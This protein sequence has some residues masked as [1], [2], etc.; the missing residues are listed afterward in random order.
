[1]QLRHFLNESAVKS[2]SLRLAPEGN[3][4]D[5]VLLGRDCM[6]MLW[7][8][9][10]SV[11]ELTHGRG[12]GHHLVPFSLIIIH[13]FLLSIHSSCFLLLFSYVCFV[14]IC[15][16]LWLLFLF[17]FFS[18]FLFSKLYAFFPFIFSFLFVSVYSLGSLGSRWPFRLCLPLYL[19]APLSLSARFLVIFLS[20]L[21]SMTLCLSVS[22]SPS[23]CVS[24]A[25][26]LSLSVSLLLFYSWLAGPGKRA[27]IPPS[28]WRGIAPRIAWW[29]YGYA[30][31]RNAYHRERERDRQTDACVYV[32][33]CVCVCFLPLTSSGKNLPV[34]PTTCSLVLTRLRWSRC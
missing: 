10:Q 12:W 32:C 25:F 3:T 13:V 4:V 26:S 31:L 19:S 17:M 30:W 18:S 27:R 34:A 33:R 14:F 6:T 8:P 5:P 23:L 2:N 29:L 9:N 24:L 22:M 7:I 16:L 28:P 21:L 1:M 20:G 11:P 15:L